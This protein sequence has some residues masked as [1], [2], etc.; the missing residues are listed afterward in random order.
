MSARVFGW[1]RRSQVLGFP[2]KTR[3]TLMQYSGSFDARCVSR[4]SDAMCRV[5]VRGS[6]LYF[7]DLGGVNPVAR[8]V[9][10][11]FGLLGVLIDLALKKR[12]QH[13]TKTM[14]QRAEGQDPELMLRENTSNF[15]IYAPEI[16]DA[17]VEP[18]SV[19]AM[20]GKQAGRWIFEMRDGKK[21]RFEFA[22]VETM[23]T[24]LELLSKSLFATLRVNVEWNDRKKKF[25]KKKT[26]G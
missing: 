8:A 20:H 12:A 14:L 26:R 22:D 5:Y 19:W 11:Q 15:K 25:E 13:R 24:A 17:A 23:K 1:T 2:D 18:P 16:K 7:I 10:A 3:P 6:D 21:Y 9:T 4:R